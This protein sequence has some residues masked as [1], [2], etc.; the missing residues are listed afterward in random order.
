MGVMWNGVPRCGVIGC[1]LW[2]DVK[3]GAVWNVAIS[4]KAVRCG[5]RLKRKMCDVEIWRGLWCPGMWSVTQD[6]ESYDPTEMWW[7]G[8]VVVKNLAYAMCCDCCAISDVENDAKCCD[9]RCGCG[10]WC[11]VKCA[12]MLNAGVVWNSCGCGMV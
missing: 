4:D 10:I 7:C 11:G 3:C 6:M 1:E 12:V 8:I 5:M 9:V 2:C